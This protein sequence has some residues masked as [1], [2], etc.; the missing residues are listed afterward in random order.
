MVELAIVGKILLNV[1]GFV[2]SYESLQN[3]FVL[4]LLLGLL[5]M[6]ISLIIPQKDNKCDSILTS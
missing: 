2:V 3:A 4:G 5:L 1:F 6:I